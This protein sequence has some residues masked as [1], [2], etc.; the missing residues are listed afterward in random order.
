MNVGSP[1]RIASYNVRNLFNEA[2]AARAGSLAKTDQE[3]QAL[4]GTLRALGA[5][6]V[7]L[8]E[9]GSVAV[10]ARLND[11]LAN[12]Y[13]FIDL[14]E[15]N[16][17]RGIHLAILSRE[18]FELTSHRTLELSDEA[19]ERLFEHESEADAQAGQSQPLR[20]QRDL[21]LAEVMLEDLG[22]LALFNVHL[23]SKTNRDWRMLAAD[24][25]RAA[26][27]RTVSE[28]VAAY[29]ARHP[30]R[31]LIV[32]GDFN[33][34]RSSPVLEPLFALPLRDPMGERLAQTG[35]NPST[36][37]PKRKM[38]LDYLLLSEAAGRKLVSGSAE[39]HASQ[40]ARR[41]SDHFPISVDLVFD[42]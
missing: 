7:L 26:E 29:L 11:L 20:I 18:P 32:G 39:I 19:G 38:R 14:L 10:L 13:P 23:K 5:D 3:L 24:T 42:D 16:S 17:D 31:P 21:M 30:E 8:Q 22:V 12:P 15:G 34:V 28:R 33:E 36:Y 41:A 2:D 37:W 9:V 6:V 40:R 27:V 1:V 25:V 35:R 4:A